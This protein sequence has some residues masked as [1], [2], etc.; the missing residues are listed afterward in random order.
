MRVLMAPD[1]FGGTLSP[2]QAATALAEGWRRASPDDEVDLAP[3]SDGG[4]GFV[5]VLATALPDA[6]RRPG[7]RSRTPWPGRCGPTCCSHGTTAYVESAQACGLH[8][9][10]AERARPAAHHDV[11]RRAARRR[12]PRRRRH[13]GS[14]SGSAAAPPTTAAPAC[15]RRSARAGSTRRATRCRRAARRSRGVERLDGGS[16][17]P[18]RRRA[19]RRVRRREPAARAVR[20]VAG[21]RPAEGRDP[22]DV[23][24]LDGALTRWADVLRGPPRAELRRPARGGRGRR[25]RRRAVRARRDRA[26]PG[27][28][29]VQEAVGLDARVDAGGPRRDRRGHAS[30]AQSLVG[31]VVSGVAPDGR[32]EHARAVRRAGR[33]GERRP[34][35]GRR[36]GRRGG[37]GRWSDRSARSAAMARRRRQRCAELAARVAGQWSRGRAP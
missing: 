19:G 24:L 37:V 16:T 18:G 12:G 11:R 26:S 5:D 33:R 25:P 20:R 6:E 10:T 17:A 1:G 35:G 32:G 28:A 29:L 9:L 7:R 34:P 22:E 30:T 4:P 31:K 3:L 8:L 36:R 21:L 14:S 2:A 15:S 23:A 27:I 13:A